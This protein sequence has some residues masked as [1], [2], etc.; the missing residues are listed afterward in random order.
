MSF[1]KKSWNFRKILSPS[2]NDKDSL[3]VKGT[4]PKGDP[5]ANEGILDEVHNPDAYISVKKKK[6]NS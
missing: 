2:T 3:K 5:F 6:K 1:T 4:K